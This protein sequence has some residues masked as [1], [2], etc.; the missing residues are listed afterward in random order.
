MITESL[1]LLQE[2]KMMNNEEIV[3]A[4]LETMIAK[5]ELGNVWCDV[6]ICHAIPSKGVVLR[7]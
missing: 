6:H 5:L 1:C 3:W 4:E 7:F 2:I